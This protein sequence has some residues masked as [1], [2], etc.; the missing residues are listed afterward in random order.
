MTDWKPEI[1]EWL[2]DLNLS[3]A[4]ENE[5]VEEL[6]VHLEDRRQDLLV[7]GATEADASRIARTELLRDNLLLNDLRQVESPRH[8]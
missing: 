2:K 8:V 7:E 6:A 4:R 3:A 5:I 1:R